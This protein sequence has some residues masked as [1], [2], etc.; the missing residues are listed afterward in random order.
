[1]Q[2][3]R[4]IYLNAKFLNNS[5]SK[6]ELQEYLL[7]LEAHEELFYESLDG[8]ELFPAEPSFQKQALYEKLMQEK[9]IANVPQVGFF[10]RY[11]RWL[12]AACVLFVG[13]GT[14]ILIFK[15]N[16]PVVELVQQKDKQNSLQPIPAASSAITL[17]DGTG[18]DFTDIAQE[19][20]HYNG[21]TLSKIGQN[22]IKLVMEPHDLPS[23]LKFHE[24]K[25]PKGRSYSLLLPDG[26]KVQLNSGSTLKVK[27]DFNLH[28][29]RCELSGEAYFAVVSEKEK[30]FYVQTHRCAVKVLGT[31]FNVKAYPSSGLTQTSLVRGKV[32]VHTAKQQQFIAPGE[33]IQVDK[34]GD[35]QKGKA[36]FREV[37]AWRD[38]YF[39]FTNAH[40]DDIL[41]DII[42]WYD[43]DAVVYQTHINKRFSGSILRSR[44][45]TDVLKAME[46]MADLKF[47]I[48]ERRIFVS[49]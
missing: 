39:R 21:I 35:M 31:E 42:S 4:F 1:M 2:Q 43:I 22:L 6:E 3:E 29:R 46:K 5:I 30:P 12:A 27:T 8:Y 32:E 7:M 36:N 25:A 16:P 45:L 17:A 20:L 37:L 44:S 13:V 34:A 9:R 10:R 24:F 28:D 11:A 40:L 49:E 26:T 14:S 15:E 47:E 38:G 33:Q 41:Q 19:E 48:K 23:G 18:L